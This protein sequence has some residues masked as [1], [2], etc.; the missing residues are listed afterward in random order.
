MGQDVGV[1]LTE[2]DAD[3]G[4]VNELHARSFVTTTGMRHL[5]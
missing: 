3:R 5:D 4:A 1:A 2:H